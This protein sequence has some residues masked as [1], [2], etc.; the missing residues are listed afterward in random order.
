M[1]QRFTIKLENN[2][3][4][5]AL[6]NGVAPM[7]KLGIDTLPALNA[8]LDYYKKYVNAL[9]EYRRD[10]DKE[11][12]PYTVWTWC[13]DLFTDLQFGGKHFENAMRNSLKWVTS[14]KSCV[15]A[16]N[17]VRDFLLDY[18]YTARAEKISQLI[19]SADRFV[20]DYFK[21]EDQCDYFK[22]LD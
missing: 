12:V 5:V 15:F 20:M 19:T 21:E 16:A 10:F 2:N 14:A 1:A 4:N 11:C 17:I 13:V 6:F 3:Y 7:K 9:P 8:L 22:F 18:G